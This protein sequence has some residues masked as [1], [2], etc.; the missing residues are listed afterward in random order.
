M[1]MATEREISTKLDLTKEEAADEYIEL[2]EYLQSEDWAFP[3]IEKV[4]RR[5]ID[6]AKLVMNLVIKEKENGRTIQQTQTDNNA[7]S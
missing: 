5:M 4:E 3:V 1:K 6:L 2:Q 7:G